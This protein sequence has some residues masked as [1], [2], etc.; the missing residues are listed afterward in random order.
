MKRSTCWKCLSVLL[1]VVCLA[2]LTGLTAC[3]KKT[4]AASFGQNV[5]TGK[6]TAVSGNQITLALATM[7]TP[8]Q[9]NGKGSASGSGNSQTGTPPNGQGNASGSGNGQTGMPPNGQ[10]SA[11]GSGNGQTG[12]PPNGQGS[13]SGSGN[14]QTGTPPSGG[15]N[16]IADNLKLTGKSKTITITDTTVIEK[17]SAQF[18]GGPGGANGTSSSSSSGAS[19]SGSASLSDIKTGTILQVTYQANSTVIQ[20]VTIMGSSDTAGTSGSSSAKS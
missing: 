9:P 2:G 13:A 11:S 6:V 19:S 5:I 12:T 8:S 18:G 10:G 7:N 15:Q 1:A 3:S 4:A 14:G 16:G 20:S 17:F